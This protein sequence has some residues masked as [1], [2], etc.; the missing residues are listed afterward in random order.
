[1]QSTNETRRN[2]METKQ[3]QKLR[4]A[5]AMATVAGLVPSMA[6]KISIAK[7]I[8]GKTKP[9]PLA[10]NHALRRSSERMLRDGTKVSLPHRYNNNG[11]S[12]QNGI[13]K[14]N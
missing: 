10:G 1:M 6:E 5:I 9:N 12:R 13:Q 8:D 11:K 3:S 4:A 7:D 2:L 14:Y